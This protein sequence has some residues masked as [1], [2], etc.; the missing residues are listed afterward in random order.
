M[1]NEV[2]ECLENP[3]AAKWILAYPGYADTEQC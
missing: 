1:L 2:E 3:M